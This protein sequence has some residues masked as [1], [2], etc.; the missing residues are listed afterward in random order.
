MKLTKLQRYT[1]YV[2]LLEEFQQDPDGIC[3]VWYHLFGEIR[4]SLDEDHLG[5]ILPELWGK[6]TTR[7]IKDRGSW[8]GTDEERKDALQQCILET[9][10]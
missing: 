8:F 2:I 3:L 9:H 5:K 4:W 7:I 6:R 1:A 10:P